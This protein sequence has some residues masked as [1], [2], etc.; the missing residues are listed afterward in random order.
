MCNDRTAEQNIEWL[1]RKGLL[2]RRDFAKLGLGAAFI[3]ALPAVAD[4]LN[5]MEQD[6]TI[7]TPDGET[8]CYF[9]H[10]A[11]GSHAAVI[12]WPDIMGLRPAFRMIGQAPR[13]IRL[14][15]TGREPV[16][17]HG[18]RTSDPAWRKLF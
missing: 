14:F 11:E 16:L 5:V 2:S 15:G 1:K 4:A 13:R 8:D 17:S 10:P 6:V 7:A 3:A 12:I 18:D 9:V